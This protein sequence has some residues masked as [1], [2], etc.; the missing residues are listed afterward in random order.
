MFSYEPI[1]FVYKFIAVV[2]MDQFSYN[3]IV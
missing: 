1:A 3:G 2:F